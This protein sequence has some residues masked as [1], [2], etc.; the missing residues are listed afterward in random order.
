MKIALIAHGFQPIPPTAWG[1]IEMTIW[2]RKVHLEK[3]GHSVDVYNTPMIHEVVHAINNQRYD[4]IHLHNEL[5][6]AHCSAHLRSPYAISNHNAG[7]QRFG[8]G[9]YPAYESI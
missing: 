6:A 7:L 4:F 5:Y 3:R 8:L 2:Q 9:G 1:P